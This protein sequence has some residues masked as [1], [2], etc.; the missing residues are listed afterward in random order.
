LLALT[1]AIATGV[2]M[3]VLSSGA[4]AEAVGGCPATF[5][6][7]TVESLGI[8]PETASG[9]PSLDGNGDALT[10]IMPSRANEHAVI[11]G[12]FIFRDNTVMGGAG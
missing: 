5:E 1:L 11:A 2:V 8:T 12:G 7:V 3:L 6:L 10:C 9:I 4:S